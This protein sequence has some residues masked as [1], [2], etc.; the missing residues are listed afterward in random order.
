MEGQ[1]PAMEGTREYIE[2]AVNR[3]PIMGGAPAKALD[4]WLTPHCQKNNVTN[5]F[6]EPRTWMD[7]L[8]K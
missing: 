3:E 1:P 6:P 4:A 7:S 2:W 5:L 8:D